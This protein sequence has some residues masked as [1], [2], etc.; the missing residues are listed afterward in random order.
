MHSWSH[1]CRHLSDRLAR[2]CQGND[3]FAAQDYKRA[4]VAFSAASMINPKDVTYWTNAAA[5]R[6][7]IGS[8]VHMSQAVADCTVALELDPGSIKALYR[9]AT[10][11]SNL[12]M[13]SEANQGG[14]QAWND[15]IDYRT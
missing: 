1:D 10:A 11:L 3:H 12:G 15:Q 14:Q 13:W 7:K 6:I 8:E 9:R 5:A 2:W 4:V